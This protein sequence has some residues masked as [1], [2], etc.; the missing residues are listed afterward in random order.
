MCKVTSVCTVDSLVTLG[1]PLVTQLLRPPRW[2]LQM[3]TR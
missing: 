3:Q 2:Q 1:E